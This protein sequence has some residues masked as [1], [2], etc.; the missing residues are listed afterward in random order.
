[1]PI[2]I[3]LGAAAAAATVSYLIPLIITCISGGVTIIITFFATRAFYKKKHE[4]DSEMQ[5]LK[6]QQVERDNAIHDEVSKLALETGI[7][8]QTLL[9]LSKEQQEE[10]KHTIQ[11]FMRNIDESDAAT[12]SLTLIANNIQDATINASTQNISLNLELDRIKNELL[13][14]Y[15]KLKLTEQ[16]LAQKE[17]ELQQTIESIGHL[18]EQILSSD[19]LEKLSCLGNAENDT[20]L[21][22]QND[23]IILLKAKNSA[24]ANTIESL[25]KTIQA[26]HK[27]LA[28]CS[29][30]ER[31]QIQE[32]QNLISDNKLL[33][34]TIESLTES[35]ES[36][37]KISSK[38]SQHTFGQLRIFK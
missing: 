12:K 31:V 13:K 8:M 21:L 2:P 4:N 35:I 19:I 27:K 36:Q 10:L 9:R 33:T 37:N 14:V 20:K 11:E 32:I 6:K 28:D 15:T 7:D 17:S 30:N 5:H 29:E 18:G 22:D 23:Q 1:M 26:L 24:L 38:V 25:N 16:N 34:E 3:L